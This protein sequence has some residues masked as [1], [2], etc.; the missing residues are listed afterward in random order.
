MLKTGENLCKSAA[1]NALGAVLYETS[2]HDRVSNRGT[3]FAI[4]RPFPIKTLRSTEN[5]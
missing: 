1:M 3:F 4:H 2:P 5:Q